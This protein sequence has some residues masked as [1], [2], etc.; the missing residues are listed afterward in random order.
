MGLF[1]QLQHSVQ[2]EQEKEKRLIKAIEDGYQFFKK[3]NYSRLEL[4][5]SLFSEE[6]KHALFEIMFFLHVNDSKY[7]EHTYLTTRIEPV[8][9]VPKEV[10]YEETISLYVD[11]SPAGVV[12]IGDLS[13]VYRNQFEMYVH[14]ELDAIIMDEQGFAPIYSI[15]S[16]GSI[17]TISHKRNASDLDLQVQYELEPFLVRPRDATD[18]KLKSYAERLVKFFANKYKV[19]KKI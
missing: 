9:G 11:N 3:F 16:L 19:L 8:H 4:A 15:A 7:E 12:G 17:G 13:P 1:E 2:F 6:M 18:E 14:T 5:F 10:E